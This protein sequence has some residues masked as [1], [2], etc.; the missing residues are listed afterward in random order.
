MLG[1]GDFVGRSVVEAALASGHDV[2]TLNR[3]RSVAPP[4]VEA[5]V[6][7]RRLSGGLDALIGREFEAVID[8][9]SWAPQAVRDSAAALRDTVG[10]FLYVSSL[11]VYADPRPAGS[12]ESAP[13]VDGDPS[14][15]DGEYAAMKRVR[16]WRS[17]DPSATAACW[18]AQA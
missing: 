1:G 3:G 16:S 15:A 5:L 12:D 18:P 4:G 13:L 8:T 17:R 10:R 14:A 11:S 6:G 9:W 2:T 7:D